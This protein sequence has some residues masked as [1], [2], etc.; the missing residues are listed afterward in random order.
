[1]P[2]N[3]LLLPSQKRFLLDEWTVEA[4]VK[5][6][7]DNANGII[8][9]RQVGTVDPDN[10][11][12]NYRLGLRDGRFYT[13]FTSLAGSM[14]TLTSPAAYKLPAG[15]WA[16]L[17]CTYNGTDAFT[18]LI[19]GAVVASK[20]ATVQ[21][22][23]VGP[24]VV[25]VKA[26]EGFSGRIDEIRLWDVARSAADILADRKTTLFG[27]EDGL[28]AYYRF[29][30]VNFAGRMAVAGLATLEPATEPKAFRKAADSLL[31]NA[32]DWLADW[33]NAATFV[34]ALYDAA[35]NLSTTYTVVEDVDS[36]LEDDLDSNN[37]MI[38]D[39]WE[40]KYFGG[41]L[42]EGDEFNDYVVVN[43]ITYGDGDGL[44]ILYEYLSGTNP[45][46][47]MTDGID[48]D[49]DRDADSDGMPNL[50]EQFF[51]SR[52]DVRDTDDDGFSDG[53]E[54]GYDYF[55]LNEFGVLVQVPGLGMDVSS[56]VASLDQPNAPEDTNPNNDPTGSALLTEIAKV[57]RLDGS[58]F[59]TVLDNP[60]HSGNTLTVA[61]W[62]R[63]D[64][65]DAASDQLTGANAALPV[66]PTPFLRRT[67]S[68][69]KGNSN[70]L[71][72][73]TKD[74]ISFRVNRRSASTTP[75]GQ[76]VDYQPDGGIKPGEW[77]LIAGIINLEGQV[78]SITIIGISRKSTSLTGAVEYAHLTKTATFTGT[79]GSIVGDAGVFLVGPAETETWPRNL[80]VDLDN[81]CVWSEVKEVATIR[82]MLEESNTSQGDFANGLV[83]QFVFDDGGVTA[84]DIV[85][86]EDW[87]TK[88]RHAGTMTE[89]GPGLSAAIG[90]GM[91]H[92][93]SLADLDSD[94]DH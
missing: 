1:A 82:I 25:S 86:L 34:G 24:G 17:A 66:T 13:S 49:G 7:G 14:D 3:Y 45:L 59:M 42:A 76:Q 11:L 56:P 51:G 33:E 60:V 67:V 53:F 93:A 22:V 9:E 40:R 52:P 26:G 20:Y 21:P 75:V 32:N 70:Y 38:P 68:S 37:N 58:N 18:I 5:P 35:G 77:Y 19:N 48:W 78:P 81:I 65:Y 63:A 83:S 88:W 79:Q 72:S 27:D 41:L 12:V 29:D 47:A 85:V 74:K 54:A 28:I 31:A 92:D 55:V 39:R 91:I 8:L 87:W 36:P 4:W 71:F 2:G 46:I 57:L 84:E 73:F 10:P 44:N 69:A 16:H 89:T 15:V 23:T 94:K 90:R 80:V 61:F 30:D 6:N 43:G 62:F 64:M 50:D